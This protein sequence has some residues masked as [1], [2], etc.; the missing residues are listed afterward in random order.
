MVRILHRRIG[1]SE[2]LQRH[3]PISSNRSPGIQP[4][5]CA[6]ESCSI[7]E[8]KEEQKERG[9]IMVRILHRRIGSSES[10]QRHDPISSNRSP[11]IQPGVCAPESCSIME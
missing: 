9:E 8:K 10:L 7:M 5:V 2:S 3:D 1:S 6:P 4:G 11:G